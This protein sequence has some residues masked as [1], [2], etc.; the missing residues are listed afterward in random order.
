MVP[1]VKGDRVG[2]SIDLTPSCGRRWKGGGRRSKS[3]LD[4][5]IPDAIGWYRG[6]HAA[7]CAAPPPP[8]RPRHR[9]VARGPGRQTHG[10]GIAAFAVN[11][12]I[13]A[14]PFDRPPRRA[15][16]SLRFAAADT[17]RPLIS[18]G[19]QTFFAT[20]SNFLAP[21]PITDATQR[22]SASGG[23]GDGAATG[24]HGADDRPVKDRR[25]L[26][27]RRKTE[28]MPTNSKERVYRPQHTFDDD[29]VDLA[30]FFSANELAFDGLDGAKLAAL[31]T[32][33]RQERA[34]EGRSLGAYRAAHE[35]FIRHQAT[36]HS[37]YMQALQYARTKF[38]EN[39]GKLKEL[40]RYRRH[41]ARNGNG[42]G[43]LPREEAPPA[44]TAPTPP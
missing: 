43:S 4:Q 1:R 40:D 26:V 11:G 28:T 30:G 33:Q 13:R 39:S 3:S 16:H 27:R 10:D 9:A 14:R 23:G 6:F 21:D 34:D 44:V 22:T 20:P 41:L 25:P 31:G 15:A 38:R 8:T 19:N 32:E 17:C 24:R 12:A 29:L 42:N 2:G 35:A 7:A 18:L 5:W 37:A 36:R